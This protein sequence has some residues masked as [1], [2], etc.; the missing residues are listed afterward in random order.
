MHKS[1]LTVSSFR[2]T[3]LASSQVRKKK[4]CGAVKSVLGERGACFWLDRRLFPNSITK[5]PSSSSWNNLPSK[6]FLGLG[7]NDFL[8]PTTTWVQLP[9]SFQLLPDFPLQIL[10][11]GFITRGYLGG[12]WR[13]LCPKLMIQVTIEGHFPERFLQPCGFMAGFLPLVLNAFV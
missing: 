12:G 13:T 11:A 8:P 5:C 3:W 7:S 9:W 2:R 6:R 4:F 1:D 10:G